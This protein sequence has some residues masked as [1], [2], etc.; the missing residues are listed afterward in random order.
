MN[1]VLV[2]FVSLSSA[3]GF[4]VMLDIILIAVL[5][6]VLFAVLFAVLCVVINLKQSSHRLIFPN[7][8]SSGSDSGLPQYLH[9]I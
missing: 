9:F 1:A 2:G 8:F 6:I 5:V 3:C 7:L 4:G